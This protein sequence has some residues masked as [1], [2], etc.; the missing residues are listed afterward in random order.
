MRP[1]LGISP[2]QGMVPFL[3]GSLAFASGR[4][5]PFRVVVPFRAVIPLLGGLNASRELVWVVLKCKA[6]G[7]F[8]VWR[9]RAKLNGS[10]SETLVL[11]S[12]FILQVLCCDWSS[13]CLSLEE[14]LYV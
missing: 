10:A 8:Y 13:Y 12:T 4:V 1:K 3:G 11:G 2:S 6:R 14:Q 9:K 7:N 5:I